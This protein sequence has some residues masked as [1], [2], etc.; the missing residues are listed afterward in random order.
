[1]EKIKIKNNSFEIC[2]ISEEGTSYIEARKV[3]KSIISLIK[4][5]SCFVEYS[6]N[7]E[8]FSNFNILNYLK[9]SKYRK[10]IEVKEFIDINENMFDGR[11]VIFFFMPKSFKWNNFILM[12]TLKNSYKDY[13]ANLII[14][15]DDLGYVTFT[16][17]RKYDEQI[18]S[19]I[20]K[21]NND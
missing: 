17:N 18:K 14:Y 20:N 7:D 4:E 19:I 11:Y 12:R 6:C 9:K 16:Y 2:Y 13:G 5:Y 21:Y 1:M 3:F 10:L 8:S 15:L